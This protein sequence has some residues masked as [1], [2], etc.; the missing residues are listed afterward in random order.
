MNGGENV[1]W[2]LTH[3]EIIEMLFNHRNSNKQKTKDGTAMVADL[4][5]RILN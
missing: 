1:G 5:G 3:R 4:G 2:K